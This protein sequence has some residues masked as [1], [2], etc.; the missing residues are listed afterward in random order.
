MTKV[1]FW[2]LPCL[3]LSLFFSLFFFLTWYS[4]L[5]I[6]SLYVVAF[7]REGGRMSTIKKKPD[8]ELWYH[9]IVG[10]LARPRDADL[11]VQPTTGAGKLYLFLFSFLRFVGEFLCAPL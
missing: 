6:V 10:N 1:R 5:A 8:E 4:L 11:S 3:F 7:K 2:G 9:R